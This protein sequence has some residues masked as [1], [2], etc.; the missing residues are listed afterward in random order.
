MSLNSF[1]DKSEAQ[2]FEYEPTP[3]NGGQGVPDSEEGG[4]Q[5]GIRGRGFV[6]RLCDSFTKAGVPVALQVQQTMSRGC[7][8]S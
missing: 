5:T 6:E 7:G 8:L 3:E 2:T 1:R 4:G